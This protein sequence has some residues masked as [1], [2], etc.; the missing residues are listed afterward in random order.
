M[1][2][3]EAIDQVTRREA[4]DELTEALWESLADDHSVLSTFLTECL[5]FGYVGF[6]QMTN[7]QLARQYL[8]IL[9]SEIVV[10]D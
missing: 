1:T 5:R 6:E 9:E 3:R 8:D 4:I 2:R 7:D 10:T